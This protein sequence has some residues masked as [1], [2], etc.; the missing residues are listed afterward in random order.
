[1]EKLAAHSGNKYEYALCRTL[2]LTFRGRKTG[3]PKGHV[4][5]VY[6]APPPLR[7]I[8]EVH[9][10]GT[11][12]YLVTGPDPDDPKRTMRN[13][14]YPIITLDGDPKTT[15]SGR[16]QTMNIDDVPLPQAPAD[17]LLPTIMTQMMKMVQDQNEASE[18][19]MQ[20]LLTTLGKPTVPVVD[21]AA[22]QERRE[23]A[24][25]AKRAHDILIRKMEA[26]A[27]R[28]KEERQAARDEAKAE[29][30]RRE[31]AEQRRHD[32]EIARLKTDADQ[33][34]QE[35]KERA[36][37]ALRIT[38]MIQ[39]VSK[40][41]SKN[42]EKVVEKLSVKKEQEDPIEGLTK[43]MKLQ[44][45]IQK[46]LAPEKPEG[47]SEMTEALK[48]AL[49]GVFKSI[50][51]IINKWQPN[52]A[53]PAASGAPQLQPGTTASV[54]IQPETPAVTATIVNDEG[55]LPPFIWPD[56]NTG[57]VEAFE[58]LGKNL[59]LA[60]VADW[61]TPRIYKSVVKKFPDGVLML[62]KAAEEATVLSTL[63]EK[64]PADA[65]LRSVR[66]KRTVRIIHGMLK[67]G[68]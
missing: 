14:K 44:A 31:Q 17:T 25:E 1:M 55:P 29:A 37:E 33:R 51:N 18:R 24:D 64:A 57:T 22:L 19:R 43:L 50:D 3:D 26:D 32:A 38:T 9:G 20:G 61:D 15:T 62:V 66:G 13:K 67:E 53:K 23:K 34:I 60:L 59:E 65:I 28:D 63:E 30:A 10:G 7:E 8:M 49:P 2:P 48:Q 45:E 58:M 36:A 16:G 46:Q 35:S 6:D 41:A 42:L 5:A 52:T 27:L 11:Y 56:D 12:H 54:P 40:E 4:L 21:E 68:R 47:P 39:E